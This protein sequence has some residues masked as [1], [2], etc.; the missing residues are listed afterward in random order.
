MSPILKSIKVISA[1]NN[2]ANKQV[3]EVFSHFPGLLYVKLYDDRKK[4]ISLL[5]DSE[6]DFFTSEFDVELLNREAD[7]AIQ[8]ARDV[9]YPLPKGLEVISLFRSSDFTEPLIGSVG[10]ILK[11]VN[12]NT[13]NGAIFLLS[14]N[15]LVPFTTHPLLGHIAVVARSD[16][17]EVKAVFGTLD[18]RKKYGTV[19]L[20]GF[21]PGDPELLTM[22]AH[23]ILGVADVIFY[24][25]LINK[26]YINRFDAEKIY[27]GKRKDKHSIDQEEINQ[28]LYH[29]A[30]NG[31]NVV[32]LKGGDPMI[33]AHGGEEIGF[34]E[35]YFVKTEVIPGVSSGI[36]AAGCTKIPLTC[37]GIS[38]SVTFISGHNLSN[39][40]IPE[41][42]TLVFYMSAST[43]QSIAIKLMNK[44]WHRDTPVAIIYNVSYPD[45]NEEITSLNNLV[46]SKSVFKTPSIII[47]GEVVNLKRKNILQIVKPLMV[48][49]E[50][51]SPLE[52][53]L[54]F[55][56][57]Q[58]F[59]DDKSYDDFI[60]VIGVFNKFALYNWILFTDKHVVRSFFDMLKFHKKDTRILANFKVASVGHATVNELNLNGIIPDTKSED[61]SLEGFVKYFSEQNNDKQ[62]ILLPGTEKTLDVI[63]KRL[64]EEGHKVKPLMLHRDE[65][66]NSKDQTDHINS[67]F[68]LSYSPTTPD[69]FMSNRK[70]YPDP[71]HY[72]AGGEK[73]K[74]KMTEKT[75]HSGKIAL[76]EDFLKNR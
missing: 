56:A 48:V 68:V 44:G 3:E 13:Q 61:E 59:K 16:S 7:I 27:V 46:N 42:G 24:D 23:K 21:G 19:H 30:I 22:K 73:T 11:D 57:D 26:E 63:L 71:F 15:E 12:Y 38:S 62:N 32:R 2:L 69:T 49:A 40:N 51:V 4:D 35:Q 14:K 5:N 28:L 18:I 66:I 33:F 60:S 43:I 29:A 67:D 53:K 72:K 58:P 47:V 6:P 9:P 65:R 74:A 52:K 8:S 1:K 76:Q 55:I 70:N 54:E 45:Q 39:A 25:D 75:R 64:E 41:T 36:A 20:V 50:T 10:E 37:R 31:K 17:Y 34:L